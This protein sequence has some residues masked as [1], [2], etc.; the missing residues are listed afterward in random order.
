MLLPSHFTR[1]MLRTPFLAS[2]QAQLCPKCDNLHDFEENCALY[3]SCWRYFDVKRYFYCFLHAE[4][5]TR[6]F[7]RRDK[8]SCAQNATMFS[9]LT[10]TVRYI[11]PVGDISP[12]NRCFHRILHTEWYARQFH[13][14]NIKICAKNATIYSILTK[15]CVISV[16]LEI[17]RRL[18]A[19]S[20]A[21]Y[22]PNAI[23]ARF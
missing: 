19:I 2:K 1:R 7:Q 4:C 5:Y 16:V 13:R 8:P 3:R 18:I 15:L 10:K 6:R 9:I 17:F 14:R 20:I 22:T 11:R 21:F 23:H 12:F